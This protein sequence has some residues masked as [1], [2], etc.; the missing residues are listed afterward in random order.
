M[1]Y[2]SGSDNK[3]SN[4]RSRDI[5][6][7]DR[8]IAGLKDRIADL[9]KELRFL[10]QKLMKCWNH[11]DNIIWITDYWNHIENMIQ[12]TDYWNLIRNII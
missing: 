6:V 12:I 7:K 9:E 1:A 3:P 11:I 8:A 10:F 4:T 5:E 2:K